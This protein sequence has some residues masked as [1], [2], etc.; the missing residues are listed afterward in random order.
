M[1]MFRPI[2]QCGSQPWWEELPSQWAA[3]NTET[4]SR[5]KSWRWTPVECSAP[6][7]TSVS[8]ALR[9]KEHFRRGKGNIKAGDSEECW[10]MQF[11]GRGMATATV[12]C[13]RTTQERNGQCAIMRGG[14]AR[15]V[16]T[17]PKGLRAIIG[18]WRRSIIFFSSV[19]TNKFC[20]VNNTPPHPHS[21]LCK[22]T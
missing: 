20:I 13:P 12:P 15:Q 14:G 17:F 2:S 1:L 9:P 19:A 8:P 22:Q 7:V 10:E 16:P 11:S 3:V 6:N 18:C 5:P 21:C 4:H